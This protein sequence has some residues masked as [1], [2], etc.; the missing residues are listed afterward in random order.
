MTGQ[1]SGQ[2]AVGQADRHAVNPMLGGLDEEAVT[3]MRRAHDPRVIK[4]DREAAHIKA[5]VITQCVHVLTGI[6]LTDLLAA[7]TNGD[8]R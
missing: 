1:G 5:A 4:A 8:M 6:D 2:A 7:E 3:A